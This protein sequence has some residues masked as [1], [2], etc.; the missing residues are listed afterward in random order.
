MISIDVLLS[1]YLP[2]PAHHS[3][4]KP[5]LRRMLYEHD[6]QQFAEKYPHLHGLDFIEQVLAYF[7]FACDVADHELE[8]IPSSGP[9][10]LVANHP[11]GTLDG[12]ALLRV[13]AKVRPDVR[14]MA[15]QLLAQVAPMRSLLFPVDNMGNKTNRQQ[16]EAMR[17]HLDTGGALIIFPAGEVSRLRPQGV[18]DGRWNP[19]FL[20]LAARSR[21]PIV[22]LYVRGRNSPLFYLTSMLY[23]PLAT[24]LLVREM[25]AHRRG[26]IQLRIGAR[27]P[28]MAW[29]D[30]DLSLE[31]LAKRF[32]KHLYRL[33][34]GKSGLFKSE[35]PIALPEERALLKREVE[36]C[37]HLGQTPDGKQIYL[38]R[39]ANQPHAP[40]LRELGRLREIAFRAVGEGTGQRRDLDKYDD[41]YL[42]LL[43]WDPGVLEIV[44]AY[45]F[46][47]TAEQL[48][49]KGT[50]GLYSHSL[51]AYG[52]QMDEV[53]Q[54]G[55]ELGRSFIQPAYWGRRG[56]DYL[57][58][59]IGAFLARNPQYRYLFG[60]VSISGSLPMAARDLLI[61]FYRLY[62][63][64]GQGIACSRNPYPASLPQV[65]AQFSGQDY[66]SDLARLKSMLDNLG[67][68]IPTLYKQYSELCER[69]GVQFMDFGT[70]PDFADC[71][72]GLVLVDLSRLKAG[73]YQRYIAIHQAASKAVAA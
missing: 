19:G 27:I 2:D 34:K 65:L 52:D 13:V 5:L 29:A 32:R 31:L 44:G 50:G 64:A 30:K 36:C 40:I 10:V 23:K 59:G 8:H 71:I 9:V 60:P 66:Q 16:I 56:L 35:A 72:D 17:T 11:I 24:L 25:F 51:F 3:W 69:G 68:A 62:F 49:H 15:N 46:I 54:Q 61:A 42:H 73:K 18:R 33:A 39:R 45:R 12:M 6:L 57:W 14:I 70:D 1:H 7:D 53:L 67:C 41:D 4:I 47:P 37:E 55:L 21:A 48:A 26:R 22:P 38:Y 58:Q 20:R 43:L 28:Y 63:P